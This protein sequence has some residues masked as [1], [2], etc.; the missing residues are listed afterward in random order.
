MPKVTYT[1]SILKNP[2]LKAW[3]GPTTYKAAPG[4]SELS[5]KGKKSAAAA[6]D[7]VCAF[8]AEAQFR[9]H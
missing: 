8:I 1:E 3:P 6:G 7:K 2:F 4:I 5:M 9:G